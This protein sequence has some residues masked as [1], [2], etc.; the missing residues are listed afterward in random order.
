MS[1]GKLLN[2]WGR[3]SRVGGKGTNLQAELADGLAV[4]ARLLRGSGRG[5]LDV[6]DAEGIEGYTGQSC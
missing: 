4:L 3:R 2:V 1:V 5:E 6:V